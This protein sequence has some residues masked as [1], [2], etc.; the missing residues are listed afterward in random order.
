MPVERNPILTIGSGGRADEL[1]VSSTVDSSSSSSFGV[2]SFSF[3]LL[4]G[5]WENGSELGALDP[6]SVSVFFPFVD[7]DAPG[8]AQGV[9]T[10]TNRT[11][12]TRTLILAAAATT[13][14]TLHC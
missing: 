12:T 10:S 1:P 7:G 6:G 3:F 8:T 4:I 11:P 9:G 2:G 14:S 5:F 13:S